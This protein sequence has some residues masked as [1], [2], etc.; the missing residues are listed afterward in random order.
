[1]QYIEPKEAFITFDNNIYRGMISGNE[2]FVKFE[3][4]D[5][6][7]LELFPAGFFDTMF[8]APGSL[9]QQRQDIVDMAEHLI[10]KSIHK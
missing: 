2:I 6:K 8:I 1:M 5:P 10:K 3:C 7:F 9:N 4:Q